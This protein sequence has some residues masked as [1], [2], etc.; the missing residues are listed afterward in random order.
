MTGRSLVNVLTSGK[1]GQVDPTRDHVLV[2]RERHVAAARDENRPYPQRAIRTA[3]HLLIRNFEPD[4]WPMG[5]GPGH[6][7][8]DG[9][10]PS[11]EQLRE[12]TFAAYGDWDASP[13]KAW[14][15]THADEPGM[16][17]YIDYAVGR[18]P[19]WELYD[20][21]NDPHCLN[22]VA[23]D[24]NYADARERLAEQLMSE[25]RATGDPRVTSDPVP[26]EHP[27]FTEAAQPRR[28]PNRR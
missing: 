15:L 4:R 12:E 16:Q 14:L 1:S 19:E 26:F 18:R 6:G 17:K 11:Y 13:T 9:P 10:L 8:P 27:P 3:D 23:D 24:V 22:N 7:A 5:T 20:L 25:L 21:A 2:G 28:R